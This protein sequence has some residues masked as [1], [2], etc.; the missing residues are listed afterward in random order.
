MFQK[1]PIDIL[2][3]DT[4]KKEISVPNNVLSNIYVDAGSDTIN[5][6]VA[7]SFLIQSPT[8]SFEYHPRTSFG[9]DWGLL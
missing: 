3:I 2:N 9:F 1:L 7:G 4:N 6:K 5:N 8:S